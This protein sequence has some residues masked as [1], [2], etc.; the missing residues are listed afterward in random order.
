MK[1]GKRKR[2]RPREAKFLHEIYE[3]NMQGVRTLLV[4]GT[5]ILKDKQEIL[6]YAK[7]CNET[8]RIEEEYENLPERSEM[9]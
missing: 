1:L 5:E 9:S 2:G 7:M 8:R 3:R 6:A 4:E